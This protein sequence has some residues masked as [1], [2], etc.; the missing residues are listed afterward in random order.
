M[1]R[2]TKSKY[3]LETLAALLGVG[4]LMVD[5]VAVA[6]LQEELPGRGGWLS[7]AGGSTVVVFVADPS[8]APEEMWRSPEPDVQVHWPDLLRQDPAFHQPSIYVASNAREPSAGAPGTSALAENLF[9]QLERERPPGGGRTVLEH[10]NVFFVA[11]G[12]AGVIVRQ[13]LLDHW[14]TL[15]DKKLGLALL[16]APG[17]PEGAGAARLDHIRK[18][19]KLRGI[20]EELVDKGELAETHTGFQAHTSDGR[21]PQ[22]VGV[23]FL[24]SQLDEA[25]GG[26]LFASGPRLSPESMGGYFGTPIPIHE[27]NYDTI[28]RPASRTS[29]IHTQLRHF[30]EATYLPST[31]AYAHGFVT[32]LSNKRASIAGAKVRANSLDEEVRTNDEG[33]FLLPLRNLPATEDAI[34]VR[35]TAPGFVAVTKTI[36]VRPLGVADVGLRREAIEEVA[37]SYDA[38]AEPDQADL[39]T[40][41]DYGD[42]EDPLLTTVDLQKD[43][44]ESVVS[45]EVDGDVV[46]TGYLVEPNIGLI[47]TSSHATE[48]GKAILVRH[49]RLRGEALAAEVYA[50]DSRYGLALLRTPESWRFPKEIRAIG[51]ANGYPRRGT[52]YLRLGYGEFE[53]SPS[54]RWGQRGRFT[55]AI[56]EPCATEHD[57][58]L[59]PK[60]LSLGEPRFFDVSGD[61]AEG[62][63]GGPLLDLNGDAIGTEVRVC[64]KDQPMYVSRDGLMQLARGAKKTPR[65]DK[66]AE[67]M[68][69]RPATQSFAAA[70]GELTE[71]EMIM[72]AENVSSLSSAGQALMREDT[73]YRC[74]MQ[75]A[76]YNRGLREVFDTH[77]PAKGKSALVG[78]VA[79]Q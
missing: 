45:I 51:V 34:Q 18:R 15:K 11:H 19:M 75:K 53:H 24:E 54:T 36:T 41:D 31:A 50:Q 12:L 9:Q 8:S 55:G 17:P 7:I 60:H 29:Q 78:E 69:K 72:W 14:E 65:V 32:N 1:P 28:A 71:L 16:A 58:R 21:N 6:A 20:D 33:R 30:F 43:H 68:E 61:S 2:L 59:R 10:D 26:W 40:C 27:S 38:G 77:V 4:L 52:S 66:L 44:L 35:V 42:F 48:P 76:Y 74:V 79:T 73:I 62:D 5:S 67:F 25:D 23:E 3:P 49:P 57:R 13:V 47:V 56:V 39:T 37:V 22:L 46:A 63:L 70:I 64:A